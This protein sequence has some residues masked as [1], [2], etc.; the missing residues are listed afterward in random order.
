[1][2]AWLVRSVRWDSS[3]LWREK[4]TDG[5][6]VILYLHAAR[7]FTTTSH[8]PFSQPALVGPCPITFYTLA[9]PF[10]YAPL[11]NQ[12]PS[13]SLYVILLTL[14]TF[15]L[16]PSPLYL[17]LQPS[18]L[19]PSSSSVL[20][21]WVDPYRFPFCARAFVSGAGVAFSFL[22]TLPALPP[23]PRLAPAPS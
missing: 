3:L 9:P 8:T 10:L 15:T 7:A 2:L 4:G 21:W 19:Q 1:M 14:F 18:L 16:Q 6:G 23:T 5:F 13:Y 17:Y 22:Q 20:L 11:A 12:Q